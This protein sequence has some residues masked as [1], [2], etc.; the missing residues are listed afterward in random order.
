[1]K[2]QGEAAP[3]H[4]YVVATPIGNLA[5]IT[6]RALKILASVDVIAAEDTRRTRKLLSHYQIAKP[7]VS[8]HTHNYPAR[9]P[10]LIRR[11]LAGQSV[12]VVSDAGTPGFSDPGAALV[13]DAWGANVPV[14]AIPGPAAGLAALSMSGF[15]GDVTF[16][17][18]LPRP[19]KKRLDFFRQLAREPRIFILYESP[20]RLARTLQELSQTMPGRQVL[21][22]RE[23]TKLFE[24]S[25]RGALEEVAGQLAGSDLKGE[26]TLV[27]SR[28]LNPDRPVI[29]LKQFLLAK[30]RETGKTGRALALEVAAALGISRRE[31]Y[32]ACLE[33][34]AAWPEP[35]KIS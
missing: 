22:V 24:E 33:L 29:D 8:C 14:Q 12:A 21:V 35:E 30:A 18:F 9:G 25:W 28:P 19:E 32:Q 6:L 34:Q 31:A 17:G 20:R 7:L 1:M 15:T 16:I 2:G 27:L 23:L 11:L 26:C 13:A 10:E 3:G 5:D 4:L